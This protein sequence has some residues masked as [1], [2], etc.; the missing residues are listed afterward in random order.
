MH[1]AVS[2]L[3]FPIQDPTEALKEVQ[4]STQVV[5]DYGYHN[6]ILHYCGSMNAA[7]AS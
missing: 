1:S 5:A 2:V 6:E 3:V 7:G 4:N